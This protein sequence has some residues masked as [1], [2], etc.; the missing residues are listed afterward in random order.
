VSQIVKYK[1]GLLPATAAGT[2]DFTESGAGAPSA[3]IVIASNAN[4]GSNPQENAY[5][6]V[7][8]FDGTNQRCCAVQ[9][10]DN[11]GG[12]ATFRVHSNDRIASFPFSE[13]FLVAD[14]SISTTTDGVTITCETD[15]TTAERYVLV[16]LLW[17]VDAKIV[18]L[19]GPLTIDNPVD[20]ASLGFEPT[21]IVALSVGD[22][23][24]PSNQ[25]WA[26][27]LS[28]GAAKS[29]GSQRCVMFGSTNNVITSQM[30]FVVQDD[31]IAGQVYADAVPWW[32]EVTSWDS[33]TFTVRIRGTTA[34][35]DYTFALALGG[36]AS[37]DVI[38][39]DTPTS[40]GDEDYTTT[41]DPDVVLA[42]STLVETVDTLETG[43][44]RNECVSIGVAEGTTEG[45]VNITSGDGLETSNARSVYDSSAIINTDYESS[46]F[47]DL[48]DATVAS[49][50]T[51]KFTLNYSAVSASAKLGFAVV[52][53]PATGGGGTPV[54]VFAHHYRQ[55]MNS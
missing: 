17:G 35:P 34:Q 55:L 10:Q 2:V 39:M 43:S 21:S 13:S 5:L 12:H 48:V 16:I 22:T 41:V 11:V 26:G 53:G 4:S 28:I 54:P 52:F 25:S 38:A 14:Y 8:L 1:Q 9:F 40:E 27:I 51:G 33:D 37:V 19:V 23:V 30:S 36:D 3:A 7:G 42:V 49:M 32:L 20:S 44:N 29:G 15:N 24:S 31:A 18:D 45:V 6:S 46:G 50:G 47:T